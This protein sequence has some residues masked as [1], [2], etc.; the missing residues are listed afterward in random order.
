MSKTSENTGS[1][2]LRELEKAKK[3][4][5]AELAA[6]GIGISP[7]TPLLTELEIARR[8][9]FEA[10]QKSGDADKPKKKKR[11]VDYHGL[12]VIEGGKQD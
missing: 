5:L 12:K 3:K 11:R 4:E 2:I 10:L 6:S 8:A 7:G 9:E 1:P